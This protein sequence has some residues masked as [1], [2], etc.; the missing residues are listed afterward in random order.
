MTLIRILG[1][2]VLLGCSAAGLVWFLWGLA[3]NLIAMRRP[4]TALDAPDDT[5][6]GNEPAND[7][8]AA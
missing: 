1:L 2:A 4:K 7:S 3:E 5:A 8:E 6:P